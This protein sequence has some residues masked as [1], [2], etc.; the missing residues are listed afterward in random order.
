M[1]EERQEYKPFEARL[2]QLLRQRFEESNLKVEDHIKVGDL[3]L[4]IDLVVMIPHPDWEP[5]FDKFPKLFDYFRHHNIIEVKTEQD[6]ME[7]E[8]LQKLLAYGWLYMIRHRIP[9][10]DETTLTA[11]V[12]HLPTATRNILPRYGFQFI[13]PG[14]Y[15]REQDALTYLVVFSETADELIPEELRAFTD[16]R[17]RLQTL[18]ASLNNFHKA[19]LIETILDLYGSEVKEIMANVRDESARTILSALSTQKIVA[20]IGKDEVAKEFSKE[21]HLT[22]LSK[23]DHLMA[24]SKDDMI[25]AIGPEETLKA[26]IAKLGAEQVQKMVGQMSQN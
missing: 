6:R 23:E 21:D 2:I 8:D 15:R 4:E 9:S 16:R 26:L 20:L 10:P 11:L 7:V 13:A 25:S 1:N 22:A 18:I 12:H 5:D 19:S 24:L 17:R 14:I 3:P